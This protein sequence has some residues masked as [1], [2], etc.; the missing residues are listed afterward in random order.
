MNITCPLPSS[1]L[2]SSNSPSA[3]G[4]S[5]VPIGNITNMYNVLLKA[6]VMSAS[7][8]PTGGGETAK[9]D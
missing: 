8:T 4:H 3:P 1:Q 5:A 7:T 9:V 2:A 6:G